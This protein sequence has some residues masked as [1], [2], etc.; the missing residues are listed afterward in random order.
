MF[1]KF[2]LKTP[3]QTTTVKKVGFKTITNE[4]TIVFFSSKLQSERRNSTTVFCVTACDSKES[5]ETVNR[6]LPTYE[7]PHA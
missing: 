2:G 7:H 1:Q 4:I 5:K 6:T 3:S